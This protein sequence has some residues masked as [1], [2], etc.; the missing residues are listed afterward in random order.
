MKSVNLA[1]GAIPF[2]KSVSMLASFAMV[3]LLAEVVL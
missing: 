2:D 3:L 1:S